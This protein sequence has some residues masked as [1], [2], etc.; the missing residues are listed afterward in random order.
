LCGWTKAFEKRSFGSFVGV[1][2]CELS[3]QVLFACPVKTPT[4]L[5][6]ENSIKQSIQI[7]F[8]SRLPGAFKFGPGN[9]PGTVEGLL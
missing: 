4:L 5:D 2:M 3:F 8:T 7:Q 6:Q 9:H 1:N